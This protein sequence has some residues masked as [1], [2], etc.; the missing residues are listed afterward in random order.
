MKIELEE[1]A[2]RNI[3]P[4]CQCM[5]M[6]QLGALYSTVRGG[7]FAMSERSCWLFDAGRKVLCVLRVL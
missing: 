4:R 6:Q 2:T 3:G 1:S 7:L 5:H